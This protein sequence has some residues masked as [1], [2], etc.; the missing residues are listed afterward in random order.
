MA[1][2]MGKAFIKEKNPGK[3]TKSSKEKELSREEETLEERGDSL[4]CDA[5]EEDGN[6][7]TSGVTD[8]YATY[9]RGKLENMFDRFTDKPMAIPNEV[10]DE[11]SSITE[12][13]DEEEV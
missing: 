9:S 5:M 12:T 4:E 6:G 8:Y 3:G 13:N 10:L 7:P 2:A 11:P 1:A